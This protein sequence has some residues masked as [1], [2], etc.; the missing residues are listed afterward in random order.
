MTDRCD[1]ERSGFGSH[2]R[3]GGA[4]NRTK[5]RSGRGGCQIGA[6]VELRAHEEHEEQQNPSSQCE[7]RHVRSKTKLRQE[8]LQASSDP[9]GDVSRW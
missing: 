7:T 5:M 8:W 9:P 1:Q 3:A 4:A 6:E 2:D